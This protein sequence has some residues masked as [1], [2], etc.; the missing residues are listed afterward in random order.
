MAV[1]ETEATQL[2]NGNDE[3]IPGSSNRSLDLK[4][5]RQDVVRSEVR[6][7]AKRQY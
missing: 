2:H 5:R 1:M 3:R 4:P 6:A 7:G